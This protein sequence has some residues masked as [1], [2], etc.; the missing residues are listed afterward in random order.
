MHEWP[1]L[2]IYIWHYLLTHY[3]AEGER[4]GVIDILACSLGIAFFTLIPDGSKGKKRRKKSSK[5]E[6]HEVRQ[7]GIEYIIKKR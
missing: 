1:L 6:I 2:F 5:T 3:L 7:R 4:K